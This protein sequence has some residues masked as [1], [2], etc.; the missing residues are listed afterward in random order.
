MTMIGSPVDSTFYRAFPLLETAR[1]RLR[2]L[3]GADAEVVYELFH[4]PEVT[5]YYDV[6]TMTELDQARALTERL[7]RRF[8]D[9]NGIRWAIERKDDGGMIGTCGYPVIAATADRGSI[10]Y[11]LVRRSWGHGFASEAIAAIVEFGHRVVQLH[12]IDALVMTGNEASTAALRKCG[13]ASE[14]ILRGYA[15]FD[16]RYRDMEMFAHLDDRVVDE[17]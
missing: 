17:S 16:G 1:L 2:E 10:G 6:V 13:F 14:G 3:T 8:H 7:Q 12:R 15:R 4:D 5:R 9:G 11:E